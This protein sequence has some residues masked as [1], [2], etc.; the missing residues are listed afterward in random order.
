MNAVTMVGLVGVAY[1]TDVSRQRLSDPEEITPCTTEAQ[2]VP[3]LL[4]MD[5]LHPRLRRTVIASSH[6]PAS[7]RIQS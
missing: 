4:V 3:L 5:L 1:Q 7:E 2:H 6:R